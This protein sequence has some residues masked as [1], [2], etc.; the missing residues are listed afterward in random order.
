MLKK[1]K[2][3]RFTGVGRQSGRRSSAH[4]DVGGS[5]EGVCGTCLTRVIEGLPDFKNRYLTPE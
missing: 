3:K 4:A 2:T 1:L 5:E